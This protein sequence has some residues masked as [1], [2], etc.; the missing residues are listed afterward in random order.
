VIVADD[1]AVL[2]GFARPYLD[3]IVANVGDGVFGN[4]EAFCITGE[5]R[6]AADPAEPVSC[7]AAT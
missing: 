5:N 2:G 3:S 1:R 4:D 7:D 6:R